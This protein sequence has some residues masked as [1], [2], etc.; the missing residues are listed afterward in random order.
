MPAPIGC[1]AGFW[2]VSVPTDRGAPY[3]AALLRG[4]VG[5]RQTLIPGLSGEEEFP[6]NIRVLP[7]SP[8]PKT[9]ERYGAPGSVDAETS[10]NFVFTQTVLF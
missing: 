5:N 7:T 6:G 10:Q 1:E 8:D 4:D 9:V 2:N 3:L